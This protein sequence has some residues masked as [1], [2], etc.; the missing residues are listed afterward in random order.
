MIGQFVDIEVAYKPG[1]SKRRRIVMAI[2][3]TMHK[4]VEGTP[5][6]II[7]ESDDLHTGQEESV[8]INRRITEKLSKL[9]TTELDSII[10]AIQHL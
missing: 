4:E 2:T 6:G 3:D 8:L 9:T 1:G 10:Y 5:G 7:V